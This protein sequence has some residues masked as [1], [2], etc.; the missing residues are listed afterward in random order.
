MERMNG[1]SECMLPSRVKT[2]KTFTD[3]CLVHI[4][5]S[6]MVEVKLKQNVVSTFHDNST[7]KYHHLS[8]SVVCPA[9]PTLGLDLPTECLYQILTPSQATHPC[10]KWLK[11]TT[12]S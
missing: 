1:V 3:N 4:S 12:L 2:E 10:E 5:S 11:N 9:R 6:L 7:L 8:S